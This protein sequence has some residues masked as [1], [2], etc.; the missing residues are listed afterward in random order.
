MLPLRAA[1]AA[2]VV[3][4]ITS[5]GAVGTMPADVEQYL[6]Q[7][8]GFSPADTAAMEDGRVIAR[9]VS[10]DSDTEVFTVAA[11][12]IRSTRQQTLSYYGQMIAYVDGK[13]TTAFGRFSSPPVLA[14][15]KDLSLDPEDVAQIK[16]CKPGKCDIRMGATG[17]GA[18]RSSIDW[19][20]PD[21]SQQ[22]SARA[23]QAVV[24]YVS[25]YAKNG[26]AALV[27]YNDRSEPVSAREQWRSI[28]ANSRYF[29]QYSAA[30]KE[31]LE[32]YPRKTLT[33]ARDVLYW[34]KEDYAGISPV[35]SIV[36]GVIYDD[37]A[38]PDRTV[39]VQKQLYA[40]HYYDGSLAIATVIGT[41]DGTA[42]Y[43]VY[44][45][46]SR[47]DL[48]KGGFGGLKRKV[49]RDQAKKSAEQTLGTIKSVL[50]AAPAAR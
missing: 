11:V 22:A 15:V 30:L 45:N 31:Y 18:I 4:L 38:R 19:N 42:T 21:A 6:L 23:R 7:V 27:M 12:K 29:Q 3:F 48:L 37:P 43:L 36:H 1:V 13:V 2:G 35:T 10:G 40:S 50:E 5:A 9:V 25:A 26:D 20:A 8:A 32:Q 44:A 24:D 49:V 34:V 33:G 41:A 39:V 14:D 46:R 17:L 16:T 47:G 28:M